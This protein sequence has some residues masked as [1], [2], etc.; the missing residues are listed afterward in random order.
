MQLIHS[1]NQDN[2][3][4]QTTKIIKASETILIVPEDKMVQTL[5]FISGHLIES[6]L[7]K[8]DAIIQHTEWG[9]TQQNFIEHL[10][11]FSKLEGMFTD[12]PLEFTFE[13]ENEK[14]KTIHGGG[15]LVTL[16]AFEEIAGL[17]RSFFEVDKPIQVT[18]GRE[19]TEIKVTST[20][21]VTNQ[22]MKHF[23]D[24]HIDY[25]Y[26]FL[27]TLLLLFAKDAISEIYPDLG[28][29]RFVFYEFTNE[30]HLN[31][32]MKFINEPS[33]I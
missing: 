18:I 33:S 17:L 11:K 4:N 14:G 32:V 13:K 6:G 22:Q 5:N 24:C 31:A 20:A 26:K 7:S 12:Y 1:L 10:T 16:S 25:V 28:T 15:M 21:E 29:N 23:V 27:Y 19:G 2:M 8:K 3:E 30:M 9:P